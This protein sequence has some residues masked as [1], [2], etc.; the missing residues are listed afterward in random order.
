MKRALSLVLSLSLAAVLLAGCGQGGGQPT[1][2]PSTPA[3][4]SASP[5]GA[6][7]TQTPAPSGKAI[8]VGY[9][10]ENLGDNAAND[11][12]HAG[13]VRYAEEHDI[14]LTVIETK[15]LQD[16]DINARSLADEG[17]DL[18]LVSTPT[19]SEIISLLAPEY[20][21][22]R[23]VISEGTVGDVENVSCW[24]TRVPEAAFLTGA[25]NALMNEHLGG[26]L[27]AA[28]VGGVRN[29]ALERAQ[30]GFTAGAE[31]VGGTGTVVYVGS[32]TDV[33]KGKEIAMQ[34]YQ[35][36]LKVIQAYAGGS[37]MGVYQ[38][39]ESMGEGYYSLGAANG[40]FHLSERIIASQV[41]QGGVIFYDC[42]QSFVD[43]TL[44]QGIFSLGVKDNAVDFKVAPGKEDLVP[45][46][47]IDKVDA[48]RT[49]IL[50]GDIVP[51]G[52]EAEY[53]AFGE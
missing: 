27:K 12:A 35:D 26:P 22:T 9:L 23:F 25:F 44:P 42:I 48:L 16:Y 14:E 7:S 52:N 20:P 30:Y 29:P 33:A 18:I 10:T 17:Y 15:E 19:A 34:L 6:P 3:S 5:S 13:V 50:N 1:P 11:D 46:E 37:G 21:E 8:R 32:F 4:P 53:N 31:F 43:G 41:K 47:V 45:Q 2:A 24:Q 49:Q 38:A 36:D 39:A 51:P 40:Q 28:F